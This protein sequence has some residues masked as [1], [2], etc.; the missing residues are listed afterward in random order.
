MNCSNRILNILLIFSFIISLTNCVPTFNNSVLQLDAWGLK[1]SCAPQP[2]CP[3]DSNS[4]EDSANC[5]PMC[6]DSG[7]CTVTVGVI[8]PKS[9][10]YIVNLNDVSTH[11][12]LF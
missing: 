2:E 3:F 4:D 1:D 12:E 6:D 7:F 9:Q 8:L 11:T 10:F 5:E